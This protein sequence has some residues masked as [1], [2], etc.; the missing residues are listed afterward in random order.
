MY[1]QV[2]VIC[3]VS[4]V[5]KIKHWFLVMKMNEGILINCHKIQR[6]SQGLI[7]E[8]RS[9]SCINIIYQIRV[10]RHKWRHAIS[11]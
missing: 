2:K 7:N 9:K 1:E 4:E 3:L 11:T 6:E 8:L 10:D 5:T